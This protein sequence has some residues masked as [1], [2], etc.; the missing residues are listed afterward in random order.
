MWAGRSCIWRRRRR[1]SQTGIKR[2]L[3][4]HNLSEACDLW[5][6]V[7]WP[8]WTGGLY[9]S[10]VGRCRRWLC[11]YYSN[12]TE[13]QSICATIIYYWYFEKR[14]ECE[15]RTEFP[16]GAWGFWGK[17]VA[18]IFT[19]IIWFMEKSSGSIP[20]CTVLSGSRE[21]WRGM[22]LYQRERPGKIISIKYAWISMYPFDRYLQWL[23]L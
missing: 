17:P 5:R 23:M 11:T 15:D 22:A 9:R 4:V 3:P 16:D 8:W 19:E 21:D 18:G 2:F 20:E 10:Y 14:P 7:Q 1:D 13:F 6:R 12:C